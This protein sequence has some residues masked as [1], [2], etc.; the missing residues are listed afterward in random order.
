MLS[1]E[2]LTIPDLGSPQLFR[3]GE[4]YRGVPLVNR[5]HPHDLLMGL[6]A[7]YRRARGG[8]AYVIGADLVG[9]P[10]L[11]PPPFMHRA[12]ARSNPQVPLTHHNTDSSHI[13]AGV[14]T[15]GADIGRMTFEASVFRG[16]EPDDRRLAFER[17]RLDSRAARVGWRRGAWHAQVSGGRLREPEWFEPYDLT[18]LTASAGFEGEIAARPF[19]ASLIWGQNRHDNGFGD[20]SNGYLFEWDLGAGLRSTLYGRVELAQKALFDLGAMH[21]K[22]FGHPHVYHAVAAFTAGSLR[23]IL[24]SR[25]GRVALGGDVTLYRMPEALRPYYGS[26][27]SYHVFLRWRPAGGAP[28]VH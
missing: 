4:S 19:A 2:A 20:R 11:G 1:L 22:G 18:R 21:P 26:S 17:P 3:T 14:V 28:H 25:A 24:R 15:I 6:G 12:S 8:V 16:A 23:E 7:K 27:R 5:Q 9:S 13:S 10:A